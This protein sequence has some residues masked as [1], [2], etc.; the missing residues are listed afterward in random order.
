MAS[1]YTIRGASTTE[2]LARYAVEDESS[3]SRVQRISQTDSKPH[4]GRRKPLSRP[5]RSRNLYFPTA[6][7][8]SSTQRTTSTEHASKPQNT[9]SRL[10]LVLAARDVS[11]NRR[12][13]SHRIASRDFTKAEQSPTYHHNP[14]TSRSSGWLSVRAFQELKPTPSFVLI[15]LKK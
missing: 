2:S 1:S 6:Q 14:K 15:P 9:P 5:R 11:A 8:P 10:A 13:W 7:S 12:A 3:N 4:S